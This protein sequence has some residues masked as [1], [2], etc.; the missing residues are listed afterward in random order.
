MESHPYPYPMF[1]FG[2]TCFSAAGLD[3]EGSMVDYRR[4]CTHTGK[5]GDNAQTERVSG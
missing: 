5:G 3:F 2:C 1:S 4:L